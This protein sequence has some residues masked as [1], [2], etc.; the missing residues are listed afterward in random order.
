MNLQKPNYINVL[1]EIALT[2]QDHLS[3]DLIGP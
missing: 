3:I 1:Q 2:P